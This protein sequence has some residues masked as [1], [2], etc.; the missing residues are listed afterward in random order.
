MTFWSQIKMLYCATNVGFPMIPIL[1]TYKKKCTFFHILGA[2]HLV[3]I[4]N[5]PSA[6]ITQHQR[7]LFP[8]HWWFR[9][10]SLVQPLW[11]PQS[12]LHS[13]SAC[14][15]VRVASIPAMAQI[16]VGICYLGVL[17][18]KTEFLVVEMRLCSVN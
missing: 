10:L 11:Q 12:V 9:F 7:H 15:P 13:T 5:G 3:T 8:L 18:T 1:G 4:S 14:A 6:P 16:H 17:Q 2:T